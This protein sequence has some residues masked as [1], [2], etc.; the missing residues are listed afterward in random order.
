MQRVMALFAALALLG[1]IS[2]PDAVAQAGHTSEEAT[3]TNP[4]DGT[5]ISIAVMKPAH[6]SQAN[7]VPVIL[8]SHGWAG[9]K[10]TATSSFTAWLDA[11]I[12]V[13]SIDQRGHGQSGDQAHVQDPTRETEDIKAVI[14]YVASLD[15][16]LKDT[17]AQ[18]NVIDNDP[19][20]G[21]IG[22]SYG[23]AYQTMTAL[24]EI[25]D[26]G[27]TRFN[28]LA[29]EISWF[30][31]NE[32][33]APQ[34][35]VRT[36]WV[37]ALYGAGAQMLP[38]YVHEAFA[39]GS[40]TGQWPDGTVFGQPAP[41]VP[42]IASEFYTHGPVYFA[43]QGI[44]IDVPILL[45]QGS[46]DNLFNLNQGLHIFED[47]LSPEARADSYFVAYNG[48]HALPNAMP[49]GSVG[50]SD[51]CSGDFT[52]FTLSFFQ[53]V[54][55]GADTKGLLPA[56]YNFTTQDGSSCLR[57]EGLGYD[58]VP[59]E[60]VTGSIVV[61]TG[62]GAP[63]HHLVAEGPITVTGIPELSG[64]VTSAVV[65]S[66]AFFALS[67]GATPATATVVQN[68]VMPLR[69]TLPV[70]G[71]TFDIELPGVAVEVPEGQNLYLT[72]SPISDIFAAH[73]S[74]V[75]GVMVLEDLELRLPREAESDDSC[76]PKGNNGKGHEKGQ[77]NGQKNGN[78]H[79]KCRPS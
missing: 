21:A 13:V 50:G 66:R 26:E 51:A 1:A 64:S 67:V 78:G 45:R 69:N 36:A 77:G 33:L 58:A 3:V 73:G 43:D 53:R 42:D 68:N 44:Q 2:P 10:S 70:I 12:G 57:Y 27:R 18:G 23:G 60:A 47:A 56:R 25:A 49:L 71:E 7:R 38:D 19:V 14:D 24:D 52:G 54:F 75:P 20:L 61:P 48:G 62:A 63:Q 28:V 22:G 39:W 72:V 11:G 46:S 6:A 40:T 37:A 76:H 5:V 30:N 9:S 17:D 79:G 32:S 41:G 65:D 15:W 74:R 35:V 55:A 31:L 29:P 4:D 16:V 8:H 34:G 59:V